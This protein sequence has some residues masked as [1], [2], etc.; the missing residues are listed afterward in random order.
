[1]FKNCLYL[2]FLTLQQRSVENISIKISGQTPPQNLKPIWTPGPRVKKRKVELC[3][4]VGICCPEQWHVS[5]VPSG[6]LIWSNINLGLL[7]FL[8]FIFTNPIYKVVH[9]SWWMGISDLRAAVLSFREKT[10][11][12]DKSKFCDWLLIIWLKWLYLEY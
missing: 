7:W 12:C 2:N 8:D 10:K 4:F 5:S 3:L 9:N 6:S 1:M 11:S